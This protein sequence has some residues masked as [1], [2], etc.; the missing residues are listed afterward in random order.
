MLDLGAVAEAEVPR[1]LVDLGADVPAEV[2]AVAFQ[3]GRAVR[4]QGRDRRHGRG[5]LGLDELGVQ[6]GADIQPVVDPIG[7]GQA[8]VA[9]AQLRGQGVVAGEGAGFILGGEVV[10]GRHGDA[11]G[12]AVADGRGEGE[13]GDQAALDRVDLGVAR[14]A[15]RRVP[16]ARIGDE[17]A[18]VP[19]LGIDLDGVQADR[20]LAAA[21]G[22]R[23]GVPPQGADA[24]VGGFAREG[25]PGAAHGLF[26]QVEG[27]GEGRGGGARHQ[28]GG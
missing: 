11:D 26:L 22:D 18:G 9:R 7:H 1:A 3:R 6:P 17:G 2:P 4:Q 24:A 20:G 28:A 16:G 13:I 10:G 21:A 5:Q 15:N 19:H 8:G 12:E 23:R 25:A 14:V 27:A